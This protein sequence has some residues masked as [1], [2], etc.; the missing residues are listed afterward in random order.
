MLE[1]LVQ[2]AAWLLHRRSDFA[3]SM[4]VLREV[5]NVKYGRFVAPGNSLRVQVELLRPTDG[6]A[7]FKA[8][9]TVNDA[10][11]VTARL[12]MAYFN[13]ARTDPELAAVDERLIAHHRQRWAVL[14][15]GSATVAT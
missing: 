12:E 2:A 1:A 3:C 7:S 4:A 8:A 5:R 14:M 13:L 11:A 6:G 15:Q 9:G 10:S